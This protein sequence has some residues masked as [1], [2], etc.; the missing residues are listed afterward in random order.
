MISRSSSVD[1]HPPIVI[2][3]SSS[4]DHHLPTDVIVRLPSTDDRHPPIDR[5]QS[6]TVTV[7]A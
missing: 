6:W 7:V 5:R 4:T 1:G 2:V 3:R